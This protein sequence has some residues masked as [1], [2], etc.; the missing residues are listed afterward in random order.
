MQ[1]K[2]QM[3]SEL[4]ILLRNMLDLRSKGSAYAHLS[5]A[6]GMVDGFMMA[7]IDSGIATRQ[8]VLDVVR[9]TRTALDG[10]GSRKLTRD[11]AESVAA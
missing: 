9:S 7:L 5:R 10:P 6:Q 8:E 11:E 1:L 2:Q 4:D 3:L